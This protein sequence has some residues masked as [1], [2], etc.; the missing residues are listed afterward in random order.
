MRILA[1][2]DT[3]ALAETRRVLSR[4]EFEMYRVPAALAAVRMVRQIPFDLMI[5]VHPLA[6]TDFAGF[7]SEIRA[8]NSPCRESQILVLSPPSRLAELDEFQQDSRL[9]ALSAA[10]PQHRLAEAA[11]RY[12]GPIRAAVRYDLRLPALWDAGRRQGHTVDVSASGALVGVEGGERPAPGQRIALDL[13]APRWRLT[14]PS[15][16]VRLTE[17]PDDK[18]RGFGV[19][20][21]QAD[22]EDLERLEE[23]LADPDRRS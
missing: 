23:L 14:L 15:E 10:Q 12:L 11:A 2:G 16:V 1:I 4:A 17:T 3:E 13:V 18:A 7:H 6:D 22:A 5:V 19:T 8:R 21:I 9:E 20:W